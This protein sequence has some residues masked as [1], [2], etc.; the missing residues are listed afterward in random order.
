M[1]DSF[2]PQ[3]GWVIPASGFEVTEEAKEMVLRFDFAA[4]QVEEGQPA[5]YDCELVRT[6]RDA[7]Y[8]TIVSAIINDR[9]N[10]DQMQAIV[11]NYLLD[12]EEATHK[13]AMDNMQAWRSHAKTVAA[14]VV[15]R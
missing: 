15:A 8:G 2:Q 14:A 6:S 4:K 10:N 7:D 5:Q 9:Y 13:E 11:N 1:K 3:A 12:P